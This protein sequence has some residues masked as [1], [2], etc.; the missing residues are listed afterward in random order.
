MVAPAEGGGA[1]GFHT[2]AEP[3]FHAAG[4]VELP[5]HDDWLTPPEARRLQGFA[6][7]KRRE[8]ARL[9]RWTAKQALALA[10]GI[11]AD[12]ATLRALVI[13]NAPDGAPEVVVDGAV[14]PVRISMT[15]RAD[16][17]VCVAVTADASGAVGCDLELVEARS[18]RFVADW[19][20]P[21]EREL[22]R[23][24]PDEHDLLANLIWSAKE[25]ALK[26]LRTGLRR[27]TRPV[28]VTLVDGASDGWRELRVVT[29]EGQVF[30]GWWRRFGVFVLSFAS[31]TG[32]PPP[33][34]VREPSP[35]GAARPSHAWMERPHRDE[36]SPAGADG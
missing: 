21:A 2:I 32:T 11:D 18:D 7:T 35:L 13:R 31:D 30:P 23:S 5:D 15:D 3:R 9:G 8:E 6:Y 1:F 29:E 33:A 17:A 16:W 27:D 24:R 10:L 36:V 22:V 34:P 4:M 12:P 20:T 25:S 28:E 14:A 26:V 19:F